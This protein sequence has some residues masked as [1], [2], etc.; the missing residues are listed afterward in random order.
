MLILVLRLSNT[1]VELARCPAGRRSQLDELVVLRGVPWFGPRVSRV[2]YCKDPWTTSR[3]LLQNVSELQQLKQPR[4]Y[5]ERWRPCRIPSPVRVGT[6]R[7]VRPH[8]YRYVH[9]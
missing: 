6:V 4:R 7:R 8:D 5:L 9:G 3:T 1:Q 2:Q